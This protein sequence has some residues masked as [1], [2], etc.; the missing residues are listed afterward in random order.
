LSSD[1]APLALG[2]TG[3][4][5]NILGCAFYLASSKS[6]A[7]R[8]VSV[9]GVVPATLLGSTTELGER[10]VGWSGSTGTSVRN[11]P[12]ELEFGSANEFAAKT[13]SAFPARTRTNMLS[14]LVIFTDLDGISEIDAHRLESLAAELSRAV[15]DEGSSG[16]GTVA[17]ISGQLLSDILPVDRASA[18]ACFPIGV[19]ALK[20]P[21]GAPFDPTTVSLV[22]STDS[23]VRVEGGTFVFV[24]QRASEASVLAVMDRIRISCSSLNVVPRFE[25]AIL[26]ELTDS[27]AGDVSS[28][29]ATVGARFLGQVSTKLH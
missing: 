18:A 17:G 1:V 3:R 14:V 2:L 11:A 23:I 21:D 4:P 9:S 28:V 5:K 16:P 7:I 29:I 20:I 22:R 12:L 15:S 27:T 8:V 25:W 10:V 6:T 24:L 19:L 13:C 26:N